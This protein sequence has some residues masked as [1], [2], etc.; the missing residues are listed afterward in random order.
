MKFFD[1]SAISAHY[2]TAHAKNNTRAPA[3]SRPERPDAKFPCE[4]CGRKFTQL[5]HMRVHVRTV[6]GFGDVKTFQCDVCSKVFVHKS[7]LARH[8]YAVHN[9]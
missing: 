3:P 7:S 2:D 6:H 1:Q 8:L 5:G 9:S 4:V